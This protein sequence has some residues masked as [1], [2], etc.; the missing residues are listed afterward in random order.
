MIDIAVRFGR[1]AGSCVEFSM[2]AHC[3]LAQLSL[4]TEVAVSVLIA[5][6]GAST[7]TDAARRNYW[8]RPSACSAAWVGA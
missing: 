4:N 3:R 8:G 7:A 6:T 2:P 1:A 5:A